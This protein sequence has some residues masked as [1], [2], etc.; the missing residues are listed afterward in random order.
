MNVK[1]LHVTSRMVG[2]LLQIF[3]QFCIGKV[4]KEVSVKYQFWHI[5][6]LSENK[7]YKLHRIRKLFKNKWHILTFI[8]DSLNHVQIQLFIRELCKITIIYTRCF[9]DN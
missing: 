2:C 9:E 8:E 1:R 3:K 7:R 4:K 6:V 5:Y